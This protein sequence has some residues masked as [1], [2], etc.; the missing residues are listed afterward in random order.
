MGVH[1]TCPNVAYQM[2]P[3]K[4]TSRTAEIGLE[5]GVIWFWMHAVVRWVSAAFT[6]IEAYKRGGGWPEES[7]GMLY[8]WCWLV[9]T[10]LLIAPEVIVLLERRL[11]MNS[12]LARLSSP[13][14]LAS[15][16]TCGLLSIYGGGCLGGMD[17][18]RLASAGVG[19]RLRRRARPRSPVAGVT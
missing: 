8:A 11:P 16:A 9:I 7:F 1:G 18:G 15:A 5:L 19:G 12:L 10:L 3:R 14:G 13:L 6:G 2:G 4:I 17:G